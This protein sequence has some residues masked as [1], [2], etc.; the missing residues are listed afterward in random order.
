MKKF[1][2]CLAICLLLPSMVWPMEIYK[3]DAVSLNIGWWGQVWYQYVSDMDTNGDDKN[4][5]NLNDF[6]IRRSYFYLQGS[7]TSDL[8]FFVDFAGDKLGMDEIID[9][10]SKGLGS[11][12][13]LRDG[14]IAYKL[15][16]NDLIVQVGRMYIPFTRNY[17]TTS[18]K[19]M[20]TTDLD[21]GQGG[22]RSGIF[23][24]SNIG[25]DDSI[26]LWGN[27]M[28]DKLQYRFMVGDGEEEKAKNPDDT[29]RFAGRLSYNFFDTETSWFNSGSYLG[30][31]HILALG[32]GADYQKD[33]FVGGGKDDYFAWTGDLHYDKPISNGDNLTLAASYI[34]VSHSANGITWTNF[35][36]GDDGYLLSVKS[37]YYFGNKVGPGNLQPFAHVQ[38]ISSDK[39]GEDDTLVYGLGM[40]Y[41]IKGADN[42]LTF[43][44]TF[45]DQ[46]KEVSN[47]IENHTI[48]T[49]QFACGF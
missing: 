9:D 32:I 24:P 27:I 39:S 18:T 22:L 38:N 31:K 45:V 43:E 8:S 37:G 2:I 33:L 14:W 21:W 7:A 23:Y 15:A 17:G 48:I 12:I 35:S 34:N 20:L 41:F 19:S 28:E 40:N 16:G 4:D 10:S 5:D 13:A 44:A 6:L 3:T 36:A 46:N 1:F 47:L 29:M 11:G 26:T 49:L 42:K 25:R 30:T